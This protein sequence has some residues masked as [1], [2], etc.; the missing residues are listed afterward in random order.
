MC[1]IAWKLTFNTYA[2]ELDILILETILS[3]I[4]SYKN[5]F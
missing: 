1:L 3:Y 2:L 5:V 4:P